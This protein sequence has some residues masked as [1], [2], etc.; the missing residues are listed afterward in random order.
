MGLGNPEVIS[1]RI[2]H[3]AEGS[4]FE[5]K[6]TLNVAIRISELQLPARVAA[7]HEADIEAWVRPRDIHV[8]AATVGEDE[9][10]VGLHEILDIK[11]GGIEKYGFHCHDLG[12]SVSIDRLLDAAEQT[13]ARAVLISTI[14]T[15]EGVH[16]QH[17]Q[18]LQDAAQ[19][20]GLRQRM[21]LIAGGAQVTD[22]LPVAVSY[23][24]GL[25]A[26]A[27]SWGH[28]GGV[29][30]WTG[31]VSA[32]VPVTLRYSVTLDEQVTDPQVI[33]NAA[34]IDDGLGNVH[35]RRALAIA[36]GYAAHLPMVQRRGTP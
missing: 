12:T 27:G 15:H 2:M 1:R 28:A 17:M 23:A 26:S 4:V 18:R 36:N 30:T 19:Q 5:I 20:R 3:P 13:G 21:V 8:V 24:G 22:T 34:Q 10:S 32:G 33:V 7:L 11:H 25:W 35:E 9:H 31:T 29:I 16:L 14:V 6:G